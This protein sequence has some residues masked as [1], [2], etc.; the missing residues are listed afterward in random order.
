M[1][2]VNGNVGVVCPK[3]EFNV[4]INASRVRFEPP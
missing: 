1:G 4:V 3:P 2:V